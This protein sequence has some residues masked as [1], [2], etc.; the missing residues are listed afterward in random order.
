[1]KSRMPCANGLTPVI[2]LVQMRGESAG[3]SVSTV[4]MFLPRRA[5]PGWAWS[6]PA[7]RG[8]GAASRRHRARE[9]SR[10]AACDCSPQSLDRR[11]PGLEVVA[12]AMPSAPGSRRHA[13]TPGRQG[14]GENVRLNS[15]PGAHANGRRPSAPL[16][17]KGVSPPAD[18]NQITPSSSY[19]FEPHAEPDAARRG[20]SH[21]FLR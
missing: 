20:E 7:R 2:M 3:C 18:P 17:K 14:D 1:M 11:G 19:Q 15:G 13:A 16:K 4:P 5:A 12:A 21:S 9:R 8:R 6:R 10:A